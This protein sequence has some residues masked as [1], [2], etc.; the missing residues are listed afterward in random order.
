ML[1]VAA[2]SSGQSRYYLS[3]TASSYYTE[4]PEPQGLWYGLGA[5]EFGLEGVVRPEE[6]T[7]LCEGYDP[8]VP[9]RKVRNAGVEE[10]P[11]ARKHET[12]R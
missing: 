1:T 3:L 4:A 9:A 2:L 8:R 6:L 10:G 7:S 11:R 5:K 12:P